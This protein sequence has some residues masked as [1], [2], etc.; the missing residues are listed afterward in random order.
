MS[1]DAGVFALDL[2]FAPPYL[3][4]GIGFR[5]ARTR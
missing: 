4:N 2:S 5:C 3:S 1:T